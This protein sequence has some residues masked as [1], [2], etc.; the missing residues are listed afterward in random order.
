[1]LYFCFDYLNAAAIVNQFELFFYLFFFLRI[2]NSLIFF[3][4]KKKSKNFLNKKKTDKMFLY[5]PSHSAPKKKKKKLTQMTNVS[6]SDWVTV[7][8]PPGK[9]A[10]SV[11]TST[12]HS[13]AARPNWS[14]PPKCP[15]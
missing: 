5:A 12:V 2:K 13:N 3:L 4:L 8:T 1:M 9:V 11:P 15:R 10:L 6:L 14:V 7:V